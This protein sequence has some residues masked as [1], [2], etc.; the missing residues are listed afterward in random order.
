MRK[1]NN[2]ILSNQWIIEEFKREIIKYFEMSKNKDT[3]YQKLIIK[4]VLKGNLNY[5]NYI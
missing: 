3:K 2:T 4:A 1:F 5:K